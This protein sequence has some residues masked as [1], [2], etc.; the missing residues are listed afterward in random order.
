MQ[1]ELIKLIETAHLKSDVPEFRAGDTVNVHVL[2][3]EGN[4]ERVQLFQGVCIK[5][6]NGSTGGTFTI[7]KISNGIGVERVFPTHSPSISKIEVIRKGVVRRA[8]LYYLRTLSGKAARIKEQ[9]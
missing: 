2:I 6:K 7:R 3:R 9:L 4:K 1:N 5:R 8:K